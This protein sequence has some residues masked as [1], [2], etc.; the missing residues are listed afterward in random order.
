MRNYA[1]A[2]QLRTTAKYCVD[3]MWNKADPEC[4]PAV[5]VSMKPIQVKGKVAYEWKDPVPTLEEEQAKQ[6]DMFEFLGQ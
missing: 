3:Y 1:N 6:T 2:H 4:S 5:M